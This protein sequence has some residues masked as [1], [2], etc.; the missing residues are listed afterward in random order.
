VTAAVTPLIATL[1]CSNPV[2]HA[3]VVHV[4]EAHHSPPKAWRAVLLAA[5]ANVDQSWWRLVGLCGNCHSATHQLLDAYVRGGGVPP[6]AV[7]RSYSPFI[8]SLAGECWA[9][10]PS[11][12]P[13][14]TLAGE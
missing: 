8:R 4:V 5:D 9:R 7:L 3:P 2:R 6:A 13:P 1:T 14:Y 10:R 11:D 12:K